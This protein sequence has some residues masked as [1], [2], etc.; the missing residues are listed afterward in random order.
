MS[1]IFGEKLFFQQENGPDVELVVYGD[2]FYAR[3]ETEDGYSVVYDP[4]K[5][6]Y[7][8]VLLIDGQFVSSGIDT[9]K[10]PP[11]S[12]RKHF[13]ETEK[14]RNEK[15]QKKY[16]LM[17]PLA[18]PVEKADTL[19]TYGPNKG[20][21]EGVRVSEGEI[22]G[23]TVLVQFKD[24]K[25]TVT[26][27]DVSKL[28]NDEGYSDNGN[29]CSVR[30]YFKLMSKGKLDYT[31]EVIGPITLKRNRIYYTQNLFVKE[32]LDAVSAMGVDLS[33]FDSM[34]RGVIDAMS[35][36]YAGQTVYQNWLWPHNHIIDLKYGNMKTNFYMLTSMGRNKADLSIGTFCHESGHMLCRWP[37]LYDYG[38]RDGDFQKSAG[39]GYYCLMSAGNHNNEG[40]TPAPV[41]AYLR[42][43]VGWCDNVVLLNVPGEHQATQGDYG[44]VLKFE[45]QKFGEYFLVEN[46]SKKGLDFYIPSEGLAIY[47]CD[48]NGSNEWQ[49][50]TSTKH[51]QCGL[52]QADGHLDLEVNQNMGDEADMF[53]NASGI[54]ISHKTTPASLMWDG[55]DSGLIISNIGEPCEVM[56]FKVEKP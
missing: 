21:L 54:A 49:G 4:E 52:L 12:V 6:L 27:D 3:Y 30:D 26:K 31:N 15:F 29:F 47:H 9:S 37:D 46:R 16:S 24:M 40:R 45:T 10:R 25:S 42:D 35:F 20:L 36:L 17:S 22:K 51:Y 33:K 32:A 23:L 5:G 28:L 56:R 8:Y 41:C 1:A 34:D 43:L 53:R 7:C 48:I 39:L 13:R 2:D 19:K 44:T 50:G 55:S 11:N 38:T 18:G 14:I